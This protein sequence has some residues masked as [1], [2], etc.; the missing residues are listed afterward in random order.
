MKWVLKNCLR[1]AQRNTGLT[2]SLRDS[3]NFLICLSFSFTTLIYFCSVCPKK[4]TPRNSNTNGEGRTGIYWTEFSTPSWKW[5]ESSTQASIIIITVN[6][7]SGI[8]FW[9]SRAWSIWSALREIYMHLSI[10]GL[11]KRTRKGVLKIIDLETMIKS[12]RLA[13]FKVARTS[14]L[15]RGIDH[16]RAS[17]VR[18]ISNFRSMLFDKNK[19]NL[20]RICIKILQSKPT[21]LPLTTTA[22]VN[23]VLAANKTKRLFGARSLAQAHEAVSGSPNSS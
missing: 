23:D 7:R 11:N 21:K 2:K 5:N 3:E 8:N 13:W 10:P 17:R 1:T 14:F 12:L 22:T 4:W 20:P 6:K 9:C 16:H 19:A 18:N 15:A